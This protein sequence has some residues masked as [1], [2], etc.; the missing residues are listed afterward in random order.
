[1]PFKNEQRKRDYMREYMRQYRE[2]KTEGTNDPD[3]LLELNPEDY[4]GINGLLR[5]V[6]E[7]I[8][9][10]KSDTELNKISAANCISTLV[11]T[12]LEAYEKAELEGRL[13]EIEQHLEGKRQVV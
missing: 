1:M 3:K 5:A 12:A 9:K 2:K 4:S 8:V 7:E 11:R 10:I 6:V 13:E